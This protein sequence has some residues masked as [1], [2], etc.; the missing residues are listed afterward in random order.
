MKEAIILAGGFGTRL[1]HIVSDVPK[2]MASIKKI[3][4]LSFLFRKLQNAGIEH[5]ILSTGY[6]HEKIEEFY[7]NNFE[8]IALTYSQETHPL[9]TGG[10]IL[11]A[12]KKVTSEDVL[13]L[14]GDTL[15][16]IDLD[17]LTQLHKSKQSVLTVALR[18]MKD[19]SRYGSVILGAENKIVAF[20]EKT[21]NAEKKSGLINGGIYI[22]QRDWLLNMNLPEKFSFEQK[23]L[24]KFFSDFDF[25]GLSF[26]S[27]FIDIGI[28]E[29]YHRAQQEL[30]RLY[31]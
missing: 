7:G 22:I 16:D 8:N 6:L 26:S 13:I 31:Q 21:Q 4:F 23:I 29:D 5:I 20:I 17:K 2:P 30:I 19:V 15:F 14:N 10:A 1:K 11:F 18:E 12:L 9:G 27:Y 24:E 3:P 28:P 25:F